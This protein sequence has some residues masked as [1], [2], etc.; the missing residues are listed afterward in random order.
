M[1]HDLDKLKLKTSSE[2]D[3]DEKEF[4]KQNRDKLDEEDIDAYKDFLTDALPA[5]D[6]EDSSESDQSGDGDGTGEDA[7]GEKPPVTPETRTFKTEEEIKEFVVKTLTEQQKE[8]KQKAIDAA[9]TVEEKKWVDENWRP[10]DW[11]EGIKTLKDIIKE[12]LKE[13][14][15][16]SE[17]EQVEK[18]EL[19]KKEWDT[20]TKKNKLPKRDTEEGKK[21]LQGVYDIG[22]KFGQTSLTNSYELWKA[23]PTD[24]GGGRDIGAIKKEKANEQRKAAAKISGDSP[25]GQKVSTVAPKNYQEL[26]GKTQSQLIRDALKASS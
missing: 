17:R 18:V 26:R 8:E 11:N 12:E 21:I 4:I 22:T 9:T 2:L 5:E 20:I 6:E 15:K 23:I 19:V 16:K 25:G 7:G 13:D 3:S 1:E 14:T 24:Q 10:K